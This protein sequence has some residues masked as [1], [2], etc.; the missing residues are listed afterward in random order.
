VQPGP[1]TQGVFVF[2]EYWSKVK[3]EIEMELL[4]LVNHLTGLI[5]ANAPVASDALAPSFEPMSEFTPTKAFIGVGSP[6]WFGAG[7]YGEYVELGT[8]PHWAPLAPLVRWV[9]KKIQ[10]HVLAVGVDF[11]SGK[12]MPTKRGTKVL[13]GDARQRAIYAIAR[14]VQIKISKKGTEG[15]L[16]VRRALDV[17]G[18]QWQLIEGGTDSESYYEIDI[19]AWLEGR[20]PAILDRV[21]A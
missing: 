5:Q 19:A 18:L 21:K 1:A 10:P 8:K 2:D 7:G 11:S 12:A 9:E 4:A 3:Q 16:F 20:L 6:L 14:A 17:L 15:K 13:R